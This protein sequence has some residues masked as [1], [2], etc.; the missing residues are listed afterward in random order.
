MAWYGMVNILAVDRHF[1]PRISL[2]LTERAKVE[3]M[4]QKELH[5]YLLKQMYRTSIFYIK[6]DESMETTTS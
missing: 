5:I 4:H 1:L 2:A 3:L 6:L